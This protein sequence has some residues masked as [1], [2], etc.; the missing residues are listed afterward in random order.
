MC[1]YHNTLSRL[2]II[3]LVLP[4]WCSIELLVENC[5]QKFPVKSYL[6]PREGGGVNGHG[7]KGGKR[8]P[9]YDPN[10]LKK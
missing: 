4:R 7:V 2:L 8:D 5:P 1:V 9:R 10:L 6:W 3:L